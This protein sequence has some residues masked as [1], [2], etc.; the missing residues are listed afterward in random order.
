MQTKYTT[1]DIVLIPATIISASEKDGSIY[2]KVDANIWD[3]I[4]EDDIRKDDNKITSN[5]LDQA[6]KE[7]MGRA[8]TY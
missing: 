3:G 5:V 2:Y 8:V 1:G 7:V 4:K 6:L